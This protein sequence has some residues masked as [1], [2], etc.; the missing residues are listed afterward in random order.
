[1]LPSFEIKTKLDQQLWAGAKGTYPKKTQSRML[2]G[3]GEEKGK[4][5]F[6]T[7]SQSFVLYANKYY[8]VV[9]QKV[10]YFVRKFAERNY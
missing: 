8:D 1:M 10:T 5:K 9:H 2:L 3:R 7:L 4:L 6:G